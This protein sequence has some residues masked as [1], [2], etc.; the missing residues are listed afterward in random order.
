MD[1]P[2]RKRLLLVTVAI[3]QLIFCGWTRS[4]VVGLIYAWPAFAMLW[5]AWRGSPRPLRKQSA[6]TWLA[7]C[8]ATFVVGGLVMS[9]ELAMNPGA[10]MPL[11]GIFLYI[12][13]TAAM[14]LQPLSLLVWIW[15]GE[16]RAG[17]GDVGG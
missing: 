12:P 17:E 2:A 13:A 9:T 16:Y 14:A 10:Q 15:R 11:S 6:T 4:I 7:I 3:G 8:G 1:A 5:S